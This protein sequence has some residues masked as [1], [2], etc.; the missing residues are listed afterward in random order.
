MEDAIAKQVPGARRRIAQANGR[1][2]FLEQLTRHDLLVLE[3]E[4]RGYAQNPL[5]IE[6]A[7][8]AAIDA[9]TK[10]TIAVTPES[11]SIEDVA[12]FYEQHKQ[13]LSQPLIRRAS[14]IELASE[15]E[16]RAT[17]A[18]LKGADRLRFAETARAR[19]QDART[20]RQGGELGYFDRAGNP[21]TGGTRAPIPR[22][23]IDAVFALEHVGEISTEPVHQEHG[24]SVVMLTGEM[25]AKTRSLAKATDDIREQLAKERETQ[26][27]QALL[28][29]LRAEY[30]PETHPEL[31]D[32]IT[33]EPAKPLDIPEGFPAAP[34]DPR[35][36]PRLVKPDKY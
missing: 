21:D 30:K 28:E 32:P 22:A 29:K 20:A 36:P 34:P 19:S 26:R 3:A 13:Q 14:Q 7:K 27:M 18:E 10:H 23:L 9:L 35:A 6:A 5:V 16:A 8:H 1:Q 31:L 12:Q 2:E 15:A 4:R 17:I 33:L 25:P 11:I 24:F